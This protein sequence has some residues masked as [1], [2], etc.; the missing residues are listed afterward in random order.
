MTTAPG[1]FTPSSWMAATRN[2][3]LPTKA[4]PQ[5]LPCA[6][7]GHNAYDRLINQEHPN[8]SKRLFTIDPGSQPATIY[9]NISARFAR[10]RSW[11][12]LGSPYEAPKENICFATDIKHSKQNIAIYFLNSQL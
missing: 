12:L 5:P 6:L 11:S 4:L 10:V 8:Q 1:A 7:C 3:G 9:Q 2:N